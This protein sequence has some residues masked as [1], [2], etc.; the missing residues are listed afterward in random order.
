MFVAALLW[1]VAVV[2]AA[3]PVY[4]TAQVVSKSPPQVTVKTSAS[5][6]AP[7][8]LTAAWGL[9][10]DSIPSTGWAT[11]DVHTSRAWGDSVQ[12]YAAGFAEGVVTQQVRVAP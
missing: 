11:L 9:F 6:V 2:D 7:D 1:L 10:N 4:F 3:A 12:M 8:A 5:F